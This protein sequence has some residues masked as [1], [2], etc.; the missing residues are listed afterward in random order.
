MKMERVLL[1]AAAGLFLLAQPV[2]SHAANVLAD[3]A[4]NYSDATPMSVSS[5]PDPAAVTQSTGPLS[6][7]L[8]HYATP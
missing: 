4:A 2:A 7:S 8:F 5:N 6:G 1:M 3:F